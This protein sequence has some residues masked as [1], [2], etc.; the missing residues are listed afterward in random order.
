[1]STIDKKIN[2]LLEFDKDAEIEKITSKIK[3]ILR[4]H[5]NRR[6]LVVAI[7]GG[8]DS[9]VSAA[10]CVKALGHKKV[11]GLLLPEKD[12]SSTSSQKGRLLAEHLGIEYE[13][14]DI[15]STLEAIGCYKWRDNAIKSVFPDYQ[16]DWKNKIT[17]SGGTAGIIN[18]LILLFRAL[19][20]NSIMKGLILNHIYK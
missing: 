7:S 11:F 4:T 10:L 18:H 14:Q 2:S 8:I 15:A 17:I 6:G 5:I 20:E 9:S 13:T 3:N 12:S 1:M 19:K 16:D